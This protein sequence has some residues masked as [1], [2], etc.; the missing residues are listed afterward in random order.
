[1]PHINAE[2]DRFWLEDL[3]D[4][5]SEVPADRD[6]SREETR[7]FQRDIRDH[8]EKRLS[9]QVVDTLSENDI[10]N[11]AERVYNAVDEERRAKLSN[12]ALEEAAVSSEKTGLDLVDEIGSIET[13]TVVDE[14]GIDQIEQWAQQEKLMSDSHTELRNPFDEG[15]GCPQHPR[16]GV[17]GQQQVIASGQNFSL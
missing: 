14:V 10:L 13:K 2:P 4:S 6:F 3:R 8:L 17:E 11:L 12:E 1:M 5:E 16:L 9:G 15:S 7:S